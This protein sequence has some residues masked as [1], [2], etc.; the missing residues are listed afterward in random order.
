MYLANLD[1]QATVF[2]HMRMYSIFKST[3][4]TL[5]VL[6]LAYSNATR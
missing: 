4:V 3:Y 1:S 2:D 6:S 5:A